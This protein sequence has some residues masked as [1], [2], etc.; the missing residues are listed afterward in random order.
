MNGS[1][2]VSHVGL[3]QLKSM[4]YREEAIGLEND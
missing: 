4:R 2:S 1:L 3:I